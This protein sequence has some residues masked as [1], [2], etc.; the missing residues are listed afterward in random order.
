MAR[1]ALLRTLTFLPALANLLNRHLTCVDLLPAQLR[2]RHPIRP[3]L[4]HRREPKT[5]KQ[6]GL[7]SSSL[8]AWAL[9]EV[10]ADRSD[11][12]LLH[13]GIARVLPPGGYLREQPRE[14][15][16][17]RYGEPTESEQSPEDVC[18]SSRAASPSRPRPTGRRLDKRRRVEG[19]GAKEKRGKRKLGY[20]GPAHLMVLLM[21]LNWNSVKRILCLNPTLL[22]RFKREL[23]SA[24]PIHL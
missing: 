1:T 11:A 23:L 21:C 16:C 17:I 13:T 5:G 20:Q 24:M 7:I 3:V 18:H 2:A 10:V 9:L 12:G 6:E 4:R 22:V 14:H 19:R 15:R 8:P